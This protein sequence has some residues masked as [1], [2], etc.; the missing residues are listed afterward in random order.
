MSQEIYTS[1]GVRRDLGTGVQGYS[2]EVQAANAATMT[3][4]Q[5][6]FFG[7]LAANAPSTTDGIQRLYIPV[8]GRITA[9]TIFARA[10]TAGTNESWTLSVRLNSTTD[11]AIQALSA[12][13]NSRTWTNLALNIAVAAGDFIEIKS[14][15][16]TWA[17]NP[18]NVAFGGTVFVRT[19]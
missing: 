15:N 12:N 1:G 19:N 9:T 14:V 10:A 16:P 13:T 17:T 4:A 11:T 6:I 18:A 5:T 7:G 3:D 8:A 2:L